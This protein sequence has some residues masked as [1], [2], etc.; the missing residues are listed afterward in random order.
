LFYFKKIPNLIS[1]AASKSL[2]HLPRDKKQ[3]ALTFDDGPT[4]EVTEYVINV[5]R[6]YNIK[7]TFFCIGNNIINAPMLFISLKSEGHTIGNHTYSHLDG[8]FTK[9]EDYIND[10][11]ATSKLTDSKLFRPPYGRITISQAKELRRLGYSIIQWDVMPGDFDEK[12][13]QEDCLR[14]AIQYTEN[15]SIIALHD[16]TVAQVNLEYMLPRYIDHCLQSGY[17]FV[18]IPTPAAINPPTP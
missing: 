3:I 10:V 9:F 16:S 2:W 15:G 5:L 11:Q 17:Q 1:S 6:Y 13:S 4:V 18:T 12:L 14:H 8:W 7:A